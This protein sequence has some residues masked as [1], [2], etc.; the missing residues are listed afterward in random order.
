MCYNTYM[1]SLKYKC[2]DCNKQFESTKLLP[3]V[4]EEGCPD[5]KSENIVRVFDAVPEATSGFV[6]EDAVF[7]QDIIYNGG[8]N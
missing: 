1:K 5:C 4:K 6:D 8:L 7:A 3:K 2:S